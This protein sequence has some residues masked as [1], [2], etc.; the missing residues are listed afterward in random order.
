MEIKIIYYKYT[1]ICNVVFLTSLESTSGS[2]SVGMPGTWRFL[3]SS[4]CTAPRKS[5]NAFNRTSYAYK[6][7]PE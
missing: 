4:G 6:S 3:T 1:I 2:D 5:Y 7:F